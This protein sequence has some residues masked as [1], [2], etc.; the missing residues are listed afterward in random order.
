MELGSWIKRHRDAAGMTQPDLASR[1]GIHPSDVSRLER[2]K[3]LPNLKVF[4][5]M[6]EAFS[7]SADEA[8]GLRSHKKTVQRRTKVREARG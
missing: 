2:D 6:C 7:A 1:C 5:R 4:V 3:Y 8:L